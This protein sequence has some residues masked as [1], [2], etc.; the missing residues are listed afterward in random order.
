MLSLEEYIAQRK[1]EDNLNEF[2]KEQHVKNIQICVNYIFEYFN[3]YLDI[4]QLEEQTILGNE[5][6]DK[7]RKQLNMFDDDVQ[8]WLVN[9]LSNHDKQ[10]NRSII[11]ILKKDELFLLYSEESEFRTVSYDC[12]AKLIKKHPYLKNDTEMLFRFIKNYHKLRSQPSTEYQ[13]LFISSEISEWFE[14]TWHK[15]HVNVYAFAE[16]YIIRFADSPEIWPVKHK[17]KLKDSWLDYEY[18]YKQ[19][20]NLFNLDNLY[21]RLPKKAFIRGKKQLFEIIFMY[22][23]LHSIVGDEENYWQEYMEKVIK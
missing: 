13:Q 7:Y 10:L 20:S 19:K 22:D 8:D 4:S 23:W 21:K 15:H 6:L 12:Y 9:I 2:N 3:N 5:K 18:D 11:S 14:S 1:K 17:I 16:D